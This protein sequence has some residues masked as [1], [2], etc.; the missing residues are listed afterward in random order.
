V[1]RSLAVAFL[2]Y[3]IAHGAQYILM[4]SILSGRSRRGW[5]A[6]LTMCALGAGIGLAIDSMKA[7][8]VIF[9]YMGLVQVHFL[10]DAKVWR[11]REPK[12]RA[13]MGN[14][15]DFLLAS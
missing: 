14:R 1:G 15:F 11:L 6:F 2:P 12:Q 5:V 8:P 7:W 9:V 13:I 4:M 3:A 10:I